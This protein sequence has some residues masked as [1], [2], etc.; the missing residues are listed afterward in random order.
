MAGELNK[1]AQI[2]SGLAIVSLWTLAISIGLKISGLLTWHWV[3]ILAP[4]WIPA[5]PVFLFA[6]TA[7]VL[8]IYYYLN[9]S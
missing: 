7:G 2:M 3:W 9:R 4:L 5:I 6:A 8:A 1:A